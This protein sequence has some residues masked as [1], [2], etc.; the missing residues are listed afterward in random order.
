MACLLVTLHRIGT[1]LG[2]LRNRVDLRRVRSPHQFASLLVTLGRDEL[3]DRALFHLAKVD[4]LHWVLR[5]CSRVL[6]GLQLRGGLEL[7]IWLERLLLVNFHLLALKSLRNH[8]LHIF[9]KRP[10]YC[11]QFIHSGVDSSYCLD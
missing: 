5:R 2:S 11:L 7:N 4:D 10:S 8:T 6:V 9:D 3:V 1:L